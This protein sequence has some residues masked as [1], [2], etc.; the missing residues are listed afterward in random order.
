MFTEAHSERFGFDD[1]SHHQ[2]A[3]VILH[4]AAMLCRKRSLSLLIDVERFRDISKGDS[5]A[6]AD[7]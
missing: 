1:V 6:T 4:F 3:T 5:P 2:Y 7:A